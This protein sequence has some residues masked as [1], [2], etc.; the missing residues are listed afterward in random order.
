MSKDAVYEKYTDFI[1]Q[2]LEKNDIRNF[3]QSPVYQEILEH[4]NLFDGQRYLEALK[5]SLLPF[6][7]FDLVAV[8]NAN[9][10]IGNPIKTELDSTFNTSPSNMRYAYHSHVILNYMNSIG[11]SDVNI[12]EIGAGYG[13][14]CMFIMHL[15]PFYGINVESYTMIDLKYPSMLQKKYLRT[16]PFFDKLEFIESQDEKSIQEKVQSNSFLV[17]NY[18]F[19]A[20]DTEYQEFY[21]EKLFPKIEHGF[22]AWNFIPV[23]SFGFPLTITDDEPKSSWEHNKFVYF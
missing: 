21:I 16:F 3:K 12:V 9:D 2:I 5:G 22:M 15:A 14:L 1:K 18:C 19:S 11:K 7:L 13:G 8:C 4:V 20:I 6:S 17:S 10:S 23:F